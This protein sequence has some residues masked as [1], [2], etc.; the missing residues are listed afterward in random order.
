VQLE[1]G[2]AATPLEKPD[3]RYDLANCQ[4]FFRSGVVSTRGYT[5]AGGTVQSMY[6]LAPTMF[7][8][9]L[10]TLTAQTNAGNL[11]SA[12][13][14]TFQRDMF[15]FEIVAAAP[16]DVYGTYSFTASADL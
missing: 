2:S 10:V 4:R 3:P 8:V 13:V 11:A 12:D 1:I 5:L 6:A 7:R 16:G 9:P 15:A 14:Q